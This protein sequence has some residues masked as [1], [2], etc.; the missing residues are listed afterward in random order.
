[1][2]G[3]SMDYL[4]IKVEEADFEESTPQRRAFREHLKAVAKALRAIE[5]NDSGDGDDEENI[6]IEACLHSPQEE[7]ESLMARLLDSKNERR[8]RFPS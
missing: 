5:W 8:R 4:Y 2:S 6:L 3:G 7:A 1:M